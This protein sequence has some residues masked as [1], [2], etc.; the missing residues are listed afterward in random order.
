MRIVVRHELCEGN[1]E[2]MKAA[3]AVFRVNED[4]QVEVLLAEPPETLRASVELAVRR[5]P[6]RALALEE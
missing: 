1:A 3:P 2:C 4:D 6:R 5:C